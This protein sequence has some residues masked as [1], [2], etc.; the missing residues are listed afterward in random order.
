MSSLKTKA[1]QLGAKEFL[2]RAQ[3]KNVLGGATAPCFGIGEDCNDDI[4]CC[5]TCCFE[6]GVGSTG[7]QCEIIGL[8]E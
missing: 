8:C 3:M 7:K 2:S 1:L 5:S 6:T 4:Q